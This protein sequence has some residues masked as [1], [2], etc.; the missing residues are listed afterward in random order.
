[1]RRPPSAGR[2]W[3]GH[4]RSPPGSCSGGVASG[5]YLRMVLSGGTNAS[6]PYFSNSDSSCSDNT[7]TLLSPGAAG[8]LSPARTNLNRQP[9]FDGSGNALANQITAP[10]AFEGV[11]FATATNSVD[12]QTGLHVPTPSVVANGSALSGNLQSFGVSWN[13]QEFNQGSPKPDGSSPGN[14]TPV[15]GTYN[16]VHRFVHAPVVKPGSGRTV[17]WL[18]RLLEPDRSIHPGG[19]IRVGPVN[20]CRRRRVEF[21]ECRRDHGC[22]NEPGCDV[23]DDI[24]RF[25][26]DN[27]YFGTERSHQHSHKGCSCSADLQHAYHL[28]HPDPRERPNGFSCARLAG[29]PGRCAAGTGP[30]GNVVVSTCVARCE[31]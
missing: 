6:G 5:T 1:M 11:R 10:V 8:G 7:Y 12:P 16:A 9:A 17:Q 15:T 24:G 19:E 26:R 20:S 18:F 29:R 30:I 23:G 3:S 14:T 13:N 4:S 28:L 2:D 25:G 31:A 21:A 22:F 27:R